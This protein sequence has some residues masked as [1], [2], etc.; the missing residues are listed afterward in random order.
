MAGHA[1][2]RQ[3]LDMVTL[4]RGQL[5][6]DVLPSRG[7]DLAEARLRGRR[8]SWESP[9]GHIPW[10]GDFARSF[11][12][13]L[14]VTCGLRNVGVPSEGQPQHGWYSSLAAR[15]V[16]VSDDRA[17]GRVV[18]A[19]V[20]GPTLVLER[21]IVLEEQLVR[22]TDVVRNDGKHAEA[23]PLLYHVNLLWDTVDVDSDEVVP[24]D[25]DARA[26]D[27]RIEGPPGPERV[28]EHVGWSRAVVERDGVC[29]TVRSSLPR[30]WQWIHP[31]Y[32]VLGIEPANCSVLGR[33]HDRAEG[34][35]PMLEPGEERASS[36]ELEVQAR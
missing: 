10:Q 32:G 15:D 30:L 18:D 17:A 9:L 8:F 14:L 35:L 19:E 28:Y 21:E 26:G 3:G 5:A 23:A 24:R 20:P 16:A 25:D 29:V 22:V 4:T 7:L 34:R 36:V 13:G 33:A 27:W 6:V 2:S 12:G 11:G 31:D 1:P